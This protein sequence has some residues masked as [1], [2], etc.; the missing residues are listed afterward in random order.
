MTNLYTG[1]CKSDVL[2]ICTTANLFE[3]LLCTDITNC[4]SVVRRKDGVMA[5]DTPAFSSEMTRMRSNSRGQTATRFYG[6]TESCKVIWRNGFVSSPR[7]SA[8]LL[9]PVARTHHSVD[10]SAVLAASLTVFAVLLSALAEWRNSLHGHLNI[11]FNA[12]RLP[13]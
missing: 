5:V 1:Q 7:I 11:I 12:S 9:C 3:R 2:F 13:Q 10:A 6:H 8:T 4:K